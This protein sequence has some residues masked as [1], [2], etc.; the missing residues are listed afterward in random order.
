MKKVVFIVLL[1]VLITSFIV[2][3]SEKN[4]VN[5]VN[6]D[7]NNYSHKIDELNNEINNF[8][9]KKEQVKENVLSKID[10]D[11]LKVYEVWEKENKYLLDALR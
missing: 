1:L 2:M 9:I 11:K 5:M 8:D 4:R 3:L 6:K 7:I 10:E